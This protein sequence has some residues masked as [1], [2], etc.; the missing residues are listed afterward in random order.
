MKDGRNTRAGFTLI[1]LLV[2]LGILMLLLTLAVPKYFG[3][4]DRA[5]EAALK[6]NLA[7]TRDALDKFY[8][9]RGSYPRTLDEL[10]EHKYLRVVP[11]DPITESKD[12]WQLVPPPDGDEGAI[13]DLHSG[14]EGSARDG[15]LYSDW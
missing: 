1:E 3:G 9:D 12:S 11:V 14:A 2:V 5:K 15:S 8:G 7:V 13:Y 4:V 6:Q 10:V